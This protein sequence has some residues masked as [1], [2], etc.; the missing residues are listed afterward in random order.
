[1]K[2]YLFAFIT[3]F[4]SWCTAYA[5][6]PLTGKVYELNT[7]I[8]LPSIKVQN[9]RTK[10]NTL[11]NANG[12]FTIQ[13]KAGDILILDGFSYQPDTVVVVNARYLEICLTPQNTTLKEVKIENTSTKLGNLKDPSLQNQ[14]LDYQRDASGAPIGGIAIRFGYGK[15]GK[16]KRDEQFVYDQQATEEIN[17]VFSPDNIGKYVP[18]KDLELK[19]FIGLYRPT[20]KQYKAPNFDLTLY[21]NDCYKKFILLTPD[22]R[23]LPVLKADTTKNQ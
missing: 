2:R 3:L 4:L 13:A 20:I 7:H 17:K 12:I 10:D 9:T 16:E 21:L 8:T 18:L 5:Q 19:Q 22:Q 1:M 14:T 23:K 6:I 15:N 11:T